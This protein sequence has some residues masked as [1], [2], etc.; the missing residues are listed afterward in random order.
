[1]FERDRIKLK[2]IGDIIIGIMLAI[3]G[4]TSITRGEGVFLGLIFVL[5]G[6]VT[7]CSHLYDIFSKKEISQYQANVEVTD[8]YQGEEKSFDEKLRKLKALKEDGIIS[9]EEYK[10]KR[11][12]ILDDKW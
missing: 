10:V 11:K 9:E 7:I 5:I 2:S 6:I 1:M 12:Q 4:V 8:S 3:L